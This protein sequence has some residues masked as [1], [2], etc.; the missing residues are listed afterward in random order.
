M[1][2]KRQVEPDVR[3]NRAYSGCEC[4]NC[5]DS[6]PISQCADMMICPV[7]QVRSDLLAGRTLLA[8]YAQTFVS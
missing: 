5:A 6:K 1:N 7:V 3:S 4:L 2:P 8:W